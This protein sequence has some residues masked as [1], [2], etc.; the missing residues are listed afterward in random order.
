MRLRANIMLT[1]S[2]SFTI[3]QTMS[4]IHWGNQEDS[5]RRQPPAH[6]LT[7]SLRRAVETTINSSTTVPFRGPAMIPSHSSFETPTRG[8]GQGRDPQCRVSPN[9]VAVFNDSFRQ[10]EEQQRPPSRA[11]SSGGGRQYSN[12]A[13]FVHGGTSPTPKMSE[14]YKTEMCKNMLQHGCCKYGPNCHYAHSEAERMNPKNI[15]DGQL[16]LPCFISAMTGAW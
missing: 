7:S 16:M 5:Q 9:S 1:S 12:N 6:V 13:N 2:F 15:P 11:G 4:F 14:K 3:P 10:G 8:G